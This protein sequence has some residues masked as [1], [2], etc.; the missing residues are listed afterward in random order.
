VSLKVSI[1]QAAANAFATWL[2]SKLAPDVVVEPRW[3]SPD[4]RKNP[5]VVTVVM[6]G[7]RRDT[8]IDL[9]Q[10][11]ATNVG[12]TQKRTVWQVAACSQP[13]QLDVWAESDVE[14]DD[15]VARLDEALHSGESSLASVFNPMLVGHGNLIA[16]GDGW[17]DFGTV[18]DFNFEEPDTDDAGDTADRNIYRATYRGDAHFMLTVSTLTAR[19]LVIKFLA[20]LSESDPDPTAEPEELFTLTPS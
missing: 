7:P 8:P 17:D 18:A 1:Q 5:R 12:A 9:R 3:P 13:F 10:L 14:L 11:S 4:K 20:Q 19:Q 6:A 16:V 2:G 15:I